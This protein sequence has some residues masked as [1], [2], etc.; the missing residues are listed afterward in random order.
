MLPG[1]N[2]REENYI[3]GFVDK[4]AIIYPLNIGRTFAGKISCI[5]DGYL[6]LNPHQGAEWDPDQGIVRK[7]VSEGF[8]IRSDIVVA[9]EPTTEQSLKNYCTYMNKQ[10]AEEKKTDK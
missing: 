10:E 6:I 8:P 7:L 5:K 9:I 3:K 4:W 2:G 1:L